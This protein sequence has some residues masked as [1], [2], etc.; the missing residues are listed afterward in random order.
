MKE[1]A[2]ANPYARGDL[3]RELQV[4]LIKNPTTDASYIKS[5]VCAHLQFAE[6]FGSTIPGGARVLDVGCGIGDAVRVLLELG[7][8]ASG[9]DVLELW[10]KDFDQYWDDREKPNGEYIKRLH[11]VDVTKYKL[12]FP[13]AHFDFAIS[14]QV[15]EHVFDYER[16]F[17][18]VARVLKPGAIS[19]HRFPGPN[20]LVEG[21][22]NVPF[23]IFCNC[24]VYL[25]VWALLGR[26]SIRQ[27]G[28]SWRQ[29][30][31]LNIATMKYA[32]YPW[33]FELRQRAEKAGVRIAFADR[34][35]IKVRRVG[36]I[37]R[38][39]KRV[40]DFLRGPVEFILALVSQRYMVIY[41][42]NK[43][44]SIPHNA[45]PFSPAPS[46]ALKIRSN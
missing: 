10:D 16:V 12:P 40:P 43:Q 29:T 42:S 31:N 7:Y 13:D 22:I 8:D 36:T 21:H 14:D 17:C 35:G 37:A 18:E 32:H 19:A 6:S 28:L 39:L 5:E 46:T 15:F 24:K 2:D 9:V 20:T 38:L 23:P 30:L 4:K 33:K 1:G 25:A 11:S 44:P 27:N 45:K 26:R 34:L 3:I 41:G